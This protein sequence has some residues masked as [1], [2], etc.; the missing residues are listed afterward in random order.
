[1]KYEVVSSRSEDLE[2][3]ESSFVNPMSVTSRTREFVPDF[4][5]SFFL[6]WFP[7]DIHR[8]LS[9]VV[10]FAPAVKPI[11]SLFSSS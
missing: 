10:W 5:S 4:L 8:S 11:T 1:M 7:H 9:N 2:P 3:E 6:A